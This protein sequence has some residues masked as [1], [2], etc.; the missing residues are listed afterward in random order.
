M[1]VTTSGA[2]AGFD[3]VC[4]FADGFDVKHGG[5]VIAGFDFF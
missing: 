5:V 3:G 2:E 4:V 1:S